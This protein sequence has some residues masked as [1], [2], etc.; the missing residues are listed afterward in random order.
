MDPGP[1]RKRNFSSGRSRI[2]ARAA[3][4][5]PLSLVRMGKEMAP[6]NS[7]CHHRA[8]TFHPLVSGE[9]RVMSTS[10]ILRKLRPSDVPLAMQLSTEAGWNQ[11]TDDWQMLI[12][13]A[14]ESCLGIE[15]DRVL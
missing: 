4:L 15:V 6:G 7:R 13:L 1:H 5:P 11:T 12:D 14:P 9:F 8:A 10:G 3:E 2:G